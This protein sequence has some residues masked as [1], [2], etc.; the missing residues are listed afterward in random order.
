[1]MIVL[2]YINCQTRQ[3][4]ANDIKISSIYPFNQN[5]FTE[6]DYMAAGADS[7][8]RNQTPRTTQA[9]PA[10]PVVDTSL[11]LRNF[12][13]TDSHLSF[14]YPPC[15]QKQQNPAI[16]DVGQQVGNNL[17]FS[18]QEERRNSTVKEVQ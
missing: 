18:L 14:I 7:E 15:L 13:E 5:V 1:M 16:E 4:A 3:I 12:D 10:P 9:M 2:S 11:P 6:A 8:E 17:K